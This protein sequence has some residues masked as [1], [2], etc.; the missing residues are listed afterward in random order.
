M[1]ARERLRIEP[2]GMSVEDAAAYAGCT[3]ATFRDWVRRGIMP[4]PIPGTH[5]YDRK[6]IDAKLDARSGLAT[7]SSELSEYGA[8]KRREGAA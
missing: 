7:T 5:R 3:I 4:G 2:R 8:W 1:T 6:A